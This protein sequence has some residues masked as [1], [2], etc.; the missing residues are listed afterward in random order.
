M[1]R[2]LSK[3]LVM[4]VLACG[5]ARAQDGFES[6]RC[7]S[8]ISRALIGKHMSNEAVAATE[9]RHTD[10]GLHNLG[11]TEVSSR[12]DSTSWSICDREYALLSDKRD[13]VRD[14]LPLPPHSRTSPEFDGTCRANGRPLHG[15]VVAVLNN[16]AATK[17]ASSHY[18][19]DDTT[20]LPVKAAWQID[21]KFQKFVALSPAGV[22]CPR[23]GII[24]QDGGP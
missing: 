5:S 13:V 6:V 24:T 15:V 9:A 20:T 16:P 4:L 19:A 3:L 1:N 17:G 2:H 18:A 7:N 12:L 8:D 11:G 22:S 21:E 14:V 10:L 23:S